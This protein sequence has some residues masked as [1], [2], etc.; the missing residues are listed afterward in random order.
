M[1]ARVVVAH[2]LAVSAARRTL[3]WF[4]GPVPWEGRGAHAFEKSA[5][6][7]IGTVSKADGSPVTLADR[8]A[9]TFLRDELSRAFPNDAVLGEEFGDQR[10]TSRYRWVIDPIDGTVSFVHGVPLYGTILGLE[11]DGSPVA[12][13]LVM[14]VLD[15]VVWGAIGVAALHE[16]G[17]VSGRVVPMVQP[18]RVSKT[19]TL[20]AATVAITSMDYCVRAGRADLMTKVQAACGVT[21]GWSDCY[22][23]MLAATGRIDAVVEP[24]MKPW[25]ICGIMPIIE[26]AG[27]T[28]TDFA[29]QR[30]T[31]SGHCIVSNGAVHAE[32][33]GVVNS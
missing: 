7:S 24:V 20:R 5:G 2:A 9:E 25:D 6:T 29:G 27:G 23:F 13:V 32:L 19:Q 10:G 8:D 11:H 4:P 14:P 1:G 21:R 33:M 15:E 28:C 26:A 3:R 17:T 31:E 16:V 30:S 22:A 12:G 18:A